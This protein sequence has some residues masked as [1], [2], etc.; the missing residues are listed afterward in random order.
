M[1]VNLY[2][3]TAICYRLCIAE[4]RTHTVLSHSPYK[5]IAIILVECS[6]LITLTNLVGIV[7]HTRKITYAILSLGTNTEVAVRLL[8]FSREFYVLYGLIVTIIGCVF[9]TDHRTARY[10]DSTSPSFP[11]SD[12]ARV[13]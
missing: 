12:R 8:F 1:A 3:A 13:Q 9:V 10:V 2:V 11:P 6:A 5:S 7:F 4:K